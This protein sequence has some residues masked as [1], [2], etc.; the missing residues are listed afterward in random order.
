MWAPTRTHMRSDAWQLLSLTQR[1]TGVTQNEHTCPI[2]HTTPTVVQTSALDVEIRHLVSSFAASFCW[3]T[4]DTP[5]LRRQQHSRAPWR[6]RIASCSRHYHIRRLTSTRWC[7]SCWPTG[8]DSA[9]EQIVFN[10]VPLFRTRYGTN[11]LA[12]HWVHCHA[13][14]Y[15]TKHPRRHTTARQSRPQPPAQAPTPCCL[16]LLRK[17]CRASNRSTN[18]SVTCTP[19]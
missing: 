3:S 16:L 8:E 11:T 9:A 13:S 14:L 10:C 5:T 18:V 4:Q 1:Q 15:S 19:S 7:S 17:S 12:L 2:V 6:R